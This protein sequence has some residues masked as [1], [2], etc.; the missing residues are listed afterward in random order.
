MRPLW[1]MS[2]LLVLGDD[3]FVV[4]VVVAVFDVANVFVV[5]LVMDDAFST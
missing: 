3:D 2:R 5:R 1:E 4:V